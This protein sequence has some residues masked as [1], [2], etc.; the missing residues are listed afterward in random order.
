[1]PALSLGQIHD[2]VSSATV[3]TRARP[4][5]SA[6]HDDVPR[7]ILAMAGATLCLAVSSAFTKY[8]VAFHPVGEVMFMRSISSF[9]I[10]A[11]FIFPIA[12]PA[13]F[14]TE[15]PKAHIA[16][17]LSQSVS[18]TFTVLAL[19]L[20][21]LAGATAISFSAPIWSAL[22]SIL[23]LRERPGAARWTFLIIG[24]AGVLIV[25]HPGADSLQVGA[26]FALANAVMYGSVTVAVRGMAKTESANT[27]LMWQVASVAFFHFFLLPFGVNSLSFVD[28]V[29]LVGSGLTNAAGQWLWTRA[30]RLG[31]ATAV[32]PFYYLTLV[33]ALAIGF[34]AWGDIPSLGLIVG[35]CVVVV[36]G[37]VLVWH[38]AKV[39]S[40]A[41]RSL[42][43]SSCAVLP[44][45][46]DNRDGNDAASPEDAASSKI[47]ANAV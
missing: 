34:F 35:S 24:F 12:G 20:M 42:A 23:W 31:P 37:L 29:M 30:L 3:K 46:G 39:R 2:A 5:Q 19:W 17:G 27:L 9:A 7:G 1:M 13:V 33:W 14:R 18:Q 22:I 21:P 44:R 47:L 25:A 45:E 15:R 43:A 4:S 10:C 11:L 6:S 28:V 38:E 41:S 32:G 16:R 36:S 40:S 26:I 8:E